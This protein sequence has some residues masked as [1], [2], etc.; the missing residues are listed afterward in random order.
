MALK[1]ETSVL[2]GLATGTLVY[3]IYQAALP[4]QAD[5]RS[6]ESNNSDISKSEKVA[7]WTSAAVVSAVSLIAKDPTIFV[8]GGSVMVALSW[9]NRHANAVAPS[10]GMLVPAQMP[11]VAQTEAP[12]T[13]ATPKAPVYEPTF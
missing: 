6:L 10:M 2:A 11:R 4:T 7:A 5:I 1:I 3:G 13:Y 9:M 12:E 8:I